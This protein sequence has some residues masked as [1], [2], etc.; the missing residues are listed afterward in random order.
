MH[1]T[2]WLIWLGAIAA[3]AIL[4][5]ATEGIVS[6]WFVGGSVA[7]LVS[8]LLGGSWLV[9]II[10]FLVVSAILLACLRPFV[11]RFVT[12]KKTATNV[13]ALLGRKAVMI[14]GTQNALDVGIVKLDGKEWSVRSMSGEALPEGSVVSIV[15][16][17][18]VTLFAQPAGAAVS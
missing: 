13:D 17:E 18:G 3:F 16:V 11:K 8:Q 7:A 4:E 12:P 6:V 9:Q 1:D 5:I 10:V 15:K 14:R 2:M